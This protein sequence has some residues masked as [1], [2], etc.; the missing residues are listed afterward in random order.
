MRA[1]SE[2]LAEK[3]R[4]GL[5]EQQRLKVEIDSERKEH[6]TTKSELAEAKANAQAIHR[7]KLETCSA[8]RAQLVQ[9]RAATDVVTHQKELIGV[10]LRRAAEDRDSARRE[11]AISMRQN[12]A[13]NKEAEEANKLSEG[14]KYRMEEVSA[15]QEDVLG[16]PTFHP[17]FTSSG[18][19]ASKLSPRL[20]S[21]KPAGRYYAN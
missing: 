9:E 21:P 8:L 16:G 19:S 7:E 15:T 14:L 20:H 6:S 2:Q 4:A 10:D 13:L 12:Q 5:I 1:E 11:L 18:A 17:R 3:V